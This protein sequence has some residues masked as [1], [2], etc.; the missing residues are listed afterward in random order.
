MIN[1]TEEN[2]KLK[3][4]LNERNYNFTYRENQILK[5]ELQNM[6]ILQEENKDLREELEG[7]KSITHDERMKVLKEENESMKVCTL[8][9][10][11]S[12]LKSSHKGSSN[13][14]TII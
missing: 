5:A 9:F 13:C 3:L 10:R 12:R 8:S 2:E 6:Y 14:F 1:L 11:F 7:Y 4:Q